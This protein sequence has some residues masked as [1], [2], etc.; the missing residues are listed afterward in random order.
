M[1]LAARVENLHKI[2]DLG[3]AVLEPLGGAKQDL[4]FAPVGADE[5]RILVKALRGVT[6]DFPEGDFVAIM[7]ASGSGKSTLLNLLGGLDRPTTGKYILDGVDVSQMDDAELSHVRNQ[8]LGFIFQSYNLI[9]QYTVLEN[10]ELPLHY[11]PGY[12]PIGPAERKRCL[13]M[14]VKVG[15][16]ER[17]DH[18]PFQLS[19]GQQQ[20]VAIARALVNNPEII[21]ADEPTG[22]L[23]SATSNEIME[24]L[25]ALN[26]EGRTIIM[27]THEPDI[28]NWAKR[29]IVMRDGVVFKETR[30]A[31]IFGNPIEGAEVPASAGAR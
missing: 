26:R 30:T 23:D 3:P 6:L 24:M 10:I 25:I 20:R 9:A 13:E 5:G 17:L 7:G 27:V 8:K 21:L 4:N 15:L 14:A 11:R 16:G 22:N 31:D 29:Q 19:G 18:R 12:P 2:Y 1:K 28:A